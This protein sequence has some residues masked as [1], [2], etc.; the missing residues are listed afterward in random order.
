MADDYGALV[1]L[2]HRGATATHEVIEVQLLD[3]RFASGRA[4]DLG[5]GQS[6]G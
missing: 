3:E 5:V 4:F 1:V 2:E 6:A